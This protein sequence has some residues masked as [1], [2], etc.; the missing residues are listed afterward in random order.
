[1]QVM[2]ILVLIASIGGILI[3]S[4]PV[5]GQSRVPI[6]G[7]YSNLPQPD[8]IHDEFSIMRPSLGSGTFRISKTDDRYVATFE[9]VGTLSELWR[10]VSISNFRVGPKG[11]DVKFDLTLHQSDPK[12]GQLSFKSK[13]LKGLMAQLTVEGLSIHWGKH[14]KLIGRAETLYAKISCAQ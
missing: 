6:V 8:P 11:S 7:C 14:S 10:P 4:C 9:E 3:L 2:R 12:S 13:M 5:S 1:M